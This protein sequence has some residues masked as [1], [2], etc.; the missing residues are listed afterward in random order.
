MTDTTFFST[1]PA[2]QQLLSHRPEYFA[3]PP[4]LPTDHTSSSGNS[5][6]QSLAC[7]FPRSSISLPVEVCEMV[8][9]H[10]WAKSRTRSR[11]PDEE[12][13]GTLRACALTCRAWLPRS[14]V[15]LFSKIRLHSEVYNSFTQLMYSAP[16]L[17]LLTRHC[18]FSC[19]RST[20][21]ECTA[22]PIPSTKVDSRY[23]HKP[24]TS[25]VLLCKR[26]LPNVRCIS[27]VIRNDLVQDHCD[28][29]K[30]L[31]TLSRVRYVELEGFLRIDK[32]FRLLHTFQSGTTFNLYKLDLASVP[33]GIVETM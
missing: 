13:L 20:S 3:V 29:Y 18:I 8:I 12:T 21:Q 7:V 2:S 19:C 15:Y 4:A 6:Y 5:E 25:L 28:L 11:I 26:W 31:R 32:I 33:A 23:A 27:L 17:G 10:I 9:D 14:R 1:P 22:H 16:H 30:H 24:I